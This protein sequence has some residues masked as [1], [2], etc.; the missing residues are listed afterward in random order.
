MVEVRDLFKTKSADTTDYTSRTTYDL[1]HQPLTVKDAEGNTTGTAYDA[2]GLTLST[3]NAAGHTAYT[4]YDERGAQV[5]T[6]TPWT[7]TGDSTVYRTTRYEYDEV[8]NTTRVT[9]PRGAQTA[10]ADDF[11]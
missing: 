1:N 7:G 9:T 3:T 6:K 10:N 2:D 11:V 4:S 8:G 5:E